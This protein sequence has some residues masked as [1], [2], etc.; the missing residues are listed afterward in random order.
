MPFWFAL[1]V[2]S[3]VVDA[4]KNQTTV[5][6]RNHQHDSPPLEGLG[7]ILGG[8]KRLKRTPPP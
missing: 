3:M 4:S 7:T 2:K 8:R 5:S 1:H 6:H